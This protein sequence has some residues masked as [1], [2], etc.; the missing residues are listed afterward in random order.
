MLFRSR[1][2]RALELGDHR[3]LH[4]SEH[5]FPTRRSSD[6]RV[7][8]GERLEREHTRFREERHV[9][10]L[11]TVFLLH[12]LLV[13]LADFHHRRHVHFVERREVR[14]VQLRVEKILGD[15]LATRGHDFARFSGS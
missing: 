8:D 3:D 11:H 10:E 5:S 15:L 7:D 2:L 4:N 12:A 1:A 14:G 13:A 6:L 9:R